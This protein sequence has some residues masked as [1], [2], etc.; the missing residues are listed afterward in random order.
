[1]A[2]TKCAI[3][4]F[5]VLAVISNTSTCSGCPTPKPK[6]GMPCFHAGS[7]QHPCTTEKCSRLCE[8]LNHNGTLAYC[9][10]ASPGVCCCP[11]E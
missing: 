5:L 1:M 2:L 9:R 7:S 3:A 10:S 8:H 6:P 4:V 11:N